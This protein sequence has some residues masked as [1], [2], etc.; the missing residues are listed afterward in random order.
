MKEKLIHNTLSAGLKNSSNS[1][2]EIFEANKV[3]KYSCNC[4]NLRSINALLYLVNHFLGGTI[5]IKEQ[6][7]FSFN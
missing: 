4:F 3:S 1:F 7:G 6:D 5:S 2:L